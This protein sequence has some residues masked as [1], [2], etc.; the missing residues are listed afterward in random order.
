[1]TFRGRRR[2]P[3]SR[4]KPLG[5][6][7]ISIRQ[8]YSGAS[9]CQADNRP[10]RRRH[11][12]PSPR[13]PHAPNEPGMTRP[14]HPAPHGPNEP[15]MTRRAHSAPHQPNEPGMTRPARPLPQR[16]CLPAS[17]RP[18]PPRLG[19]RRTCQAR[20]PKPARAL[21]TAIVKSHKGPASTFRFIL[22][23]PVL[24]LEDFPWRIQALCQFRRPVVHQ[25][26]HK[27]RNYHDILAID[28]TMTRSR[29]TAPTGTTARIGIA[30]LVPERAS[31]ALA[32]GQIPGWACLVW[33]AVRVPTL[34]ASGS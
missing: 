3:A 29:I 6:L 26:L 11:D 7:S 19:L 34:P 25:I 13:A 20:N 12:P 15:C 33:Q 1:V 30:W 21:P 32:A 14:A 5:P 22:R 23:S 24:V 17:P 28:R 16:S 9:R 2:P 8:G 4:P 10:E 27:A 18:A 31:Q